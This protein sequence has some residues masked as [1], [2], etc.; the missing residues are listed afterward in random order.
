M[1]MTITLG[2]A[3]LGNQ[4]MCIIHQIRKCRH[5]IQ[6]LTSSPG[7]CIQPAAAEGEAEKQ[8]KQEKL[9][10]KEEKEDND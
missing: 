2:K 7:Y 8:E 1:G 6:S 4:S 3:G 5:S 10:Q 9:K